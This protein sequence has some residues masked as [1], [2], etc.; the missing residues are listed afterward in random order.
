MEQLLNS[1]AV[2]NEKIDPDNPETRL[3]QQLLMYLRR[4]SL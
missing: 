1:P 2:L 4:A 3:M